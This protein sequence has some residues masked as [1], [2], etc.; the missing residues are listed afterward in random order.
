MREIC[1]KN[2][3][4]FV[5][6]SLEWCETR[7]VSGVCL[8]GVC[9]LINKISLRRWMTSHFLLLLMSGED[10]A[11]IF[12]ALLRIWSKIRITGLHCGLFRQ[13]LRAEIEPWDFEVFFYVSII[14]FLIKSYFIA[15][16]GQTTSDTH[17]TATNACHH[18]S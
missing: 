1:I 16:C 18:P 7:R 2:L 8:L 5:I 3:D 10:K 4:F 12:L 6:L 11:Q 14:S 13:F 17:P 15:Y 9:C